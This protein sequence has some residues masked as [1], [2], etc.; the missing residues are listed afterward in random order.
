MQSTTV[1][2]TE[3][4]HLDVPG[5]FDKAFEIDGTVAERSCR[6]LLRRFH[7]LSQLPSRPYRAHADA[8]TVC[9]RLDQEGISHGGGNF[10]DLTRVADGDPAAAGQHGDASGLRDLPRTLLLAHGASALGRGADPDEARLL[11]AA[12]EVGILGQEAVAGMDRI[13]ARAGRRLQDAGAVQV[14]L[15]RRRLAD[16]DP[17]VH[18]PYAQSVTIRL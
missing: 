7:G 10:V 15:Q 16:G 18:H 12:C 17:L 1:A 14:A 6:H 13:G 9:S 2:V 11:S 5:T 8:A 3:N 4:L